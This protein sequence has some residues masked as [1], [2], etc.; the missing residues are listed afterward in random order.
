[1]ILISEDNRVHL[2]DE[3]IG[4]HQQAAFSRQIIS[5][6]L[7]TE[8]VMVGFESIWTFEGYNLIGLD[9]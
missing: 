1:M 5:P 8:D 7:I 2:L 4:S 6:Y 9:Q 3:K